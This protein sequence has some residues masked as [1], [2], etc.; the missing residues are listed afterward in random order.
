MFQAMGDA[1]ETEALSPY[2]DQ[3]LN[4]G[5]ERLAAMYGAGTP[6]PLTR[7]ADQ[8]TLPEWM[9]PAIAD[10]AAWMLLRNGNPQRQ[11]RGMQFRAAYEEAAA[12][13]RREGGLSQRE[14]AGRVGVTESTL[15][16]WL[17]ME[18]FA[19]LRRETMERL[20]EETRPRVLEVLKRQLEDEDK[21]IAQQAA[22]HL[23]KLAEAAREK[24]ETGAVQVR[25][26]YMPRPGEASDGSA[27]K[28]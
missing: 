3:Y 13:I 25:F 6:A 4:E 2:V 24:E 18:A 20:L 19:A 12:R 27:E 16:N 28:G 9:H 11:A 5:Y 10:F 15:R 8:P 23:M 22:N 26:L 21:R 14:A 1:E 17:R 7:K